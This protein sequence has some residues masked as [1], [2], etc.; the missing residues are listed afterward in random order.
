M[1]PLHAH[2]WLIYTHNWSHLFWDDLIWPFPLWDE[3]DI[4][5]S[6]LS[7]LAC[8]VLT[9]LWVPCPW[10]CL[11]TIQTASFERILRNII[12]PRDPSEQRAAALIV[13]MWRWVLVTSH[14][15][16]FIYPMCI[17]NL[18]QILLPHVHTIY[19]MLPYP[20][21]TTPHTLSQVLP[22]WQEQQCVTSPSVPIVSMHEYKS[23]TCN[24]LYEL[25]ALF[26]NATNGPC[27]Y[28]GDYHNLLSQYYSIPAV[29]VRNGGFK[30]TCSR[31]YLSRALCAVTDKGGQV[32]L[33]FVGKYPL[34]FVMSLIHVYS[35]KGWYLFGY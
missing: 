15:H 28:R 17:S 32:R 5:F 35:G 26:D 9:V 34:M 3:A 2:T 23:A 20:H 30:C 11:F 18:V 13:N 1:R 22:C 29:A 12:K 8:F 14:E 33:R 6:M 7:S 25:S 27:S 16:V 31:S 21:V 4:C 19:M 24:M 10:I